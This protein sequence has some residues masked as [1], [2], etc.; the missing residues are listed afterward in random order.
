M[1][2]T[3][4]YLSSTLSMIAMVFYV[5]GSIGYATDKD[6]IRNVAWITAEQSGVNVYYALKKVYI[7]GQGTEQ[8]QSYSDCSNNNGNVC[9]Q[10]EED[11]QGSFTL[12]VIGAVI[13]LCTMSVCGS[14]SRTVSFPMQLVSIV[15]AA[16]ACAAG[17]ISLS[18]FMGNCYDKLDDQTNVD[19]EWGS[20]S[21]LVLIAMFLMAGVGGI[22]ILSTFICVST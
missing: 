20:G 16:A 18:L 17:V 11:G 12:C 8:E 21:V 9:D 7:K 22:Q 4:N 13:A 14:L 2:P 1:S 3:L 6:V 15:F 19:L 5:I 10:C